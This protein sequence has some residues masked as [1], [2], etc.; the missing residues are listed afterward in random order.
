MNSSATVSR[1]S[2]DLSSYPDL[3]VIYLGM[4]VNAARG[5]GALLGIGPKLSAFG[6]QKPEGLLSQDIFLFSLRHAGIRQYWRDLESLEAFT[7]SDPH[8]TWWRN[9]TK[10]SH[11]AGIWHESYRLR[12][13]MEGI[14]MNMPPFGFSSFA[15]SL[16]PVGARQSA[17]GRLAS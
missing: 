11:G 14:Y 15:P 7:R 4:R 16:D 17:R 8:R 10:D 12:G 1:R 6:A 9:F 5:I 3:V 13:G 2:V